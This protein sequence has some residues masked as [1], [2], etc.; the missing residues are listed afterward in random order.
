M[1]VAVSADN[2]FT[3]MT[4]PML[5]CRIPCAMW[6]TWSQTLR[7]ARDS[8][9]PPRCFAGPCLPLKELLEH[10]K[11]EPCTVLDCSGSSLLHV[12]A[13]HGR[14]EC[15]RLLLAGQ[16]L[17]R[18]GS[19]PLNIDARDTKGRTALFNA[20]TNAFVDVAA[21]LLDFGACELFER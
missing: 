17:Q 5:P 1:F 16:W 8:P 18:E 13:T 11:V 15:A 20:A 14:L 10:G 21:F 3:R 7:Q 12:A 9:Y 6:R 19:V 2:R 4:T